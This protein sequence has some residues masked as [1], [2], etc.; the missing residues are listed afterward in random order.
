MR[1]GLNGQRRSFIPSH[2]RCRRQCP[3]RRGVRPVARISLDSVSPW[4]QRRCVSRP[5]HGPVRLDREAAARQTEARTGTSPRCRGFGP[6]R[7]FGVFSGRS[8]EFAGYQ[9]GVA[10]YIRPEI[11]SDRPI[12]LRGEVAK[13]LTAPVLKTGRAKA[14]V[15]SN[16][17]LSATWP[18]CACATGKTNASDVTNTGGL[19]NVGCLLGWPLEVEGHLHDVNVEVAEA[20][21]A[22]CRQHVADPEPE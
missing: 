7:S 19:R 4:R 11:R 13:R 2:L 22:A 20:F 8:A 6:Q 21:E 1:F 5:A 14:L 15:G 10:G 18:A 9:A 12:P 16:P 3:A 17:T